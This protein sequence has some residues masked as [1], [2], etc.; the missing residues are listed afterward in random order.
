M[1][2]DAELFVTEVSLALGLASLPKEKPVPK[3][4]LEVMAQGIQHERK[5]FVALLA[6]Y[7]L[8]KEVDAGVVIELLQGWNERRVQPP[9]REDEVS[10]AVTNV[11]NWNLRQRE[12]AVTGLEKLESLVAVLASTAPETP[13]Y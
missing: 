4:F 1:K 9:L 6:D 10:V 11:M 12:G 8:S 5:G 13:K 2:D 7:L 3:N